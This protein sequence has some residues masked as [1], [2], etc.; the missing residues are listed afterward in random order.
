MRFLNFMRARIS[1][2]VKGLTDKSVSQLY[3]AKYFLTDPRCQIFMQ[4]IKMALI[5]MPILRWKYTISSSIFSGCGKF[6]YPSLWHWLAFNLGLFLV[7]ITVIIL[8]TG[9]F[10]TTK[11]YIL[12]SKFFE[13]NGHPKLSYIAFSDFHMST[14]KQGDLFDTICLSIYLVFFHTL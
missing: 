8:I 9:W 7:L 5:W 10:V 12:P 4:P 3:I 13:L 6:L 2:T 11:N 1:Q 14:N